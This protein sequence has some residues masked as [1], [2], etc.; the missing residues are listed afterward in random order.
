MKIL[1]PVSHPNEV[2]ALIKAGASQLYCGVLPKE[3][4]NTYTNIAPPNRREYAGANL[5]S[6]TQLKEVIIRSSKHKIG[7]MFTLNTDYAKSQYPQI[8]EYAKKAVSLGISGLLVADLSLVYLLK[9]KN[10]N[11]PIYMSVVNP[12]FNSKTIGL[13]RSMGI[14][15][16]TLDRHF[17]LKEIKMIVLSNP[18]MQFELF[19]LNAGSKNVDGFCG[20]CHGIS[21]LKTKKPEVIFD[22]AACY[23]NYNVKPQGAAKRGSLSI[24]ERIKKA[25]PYQYSGRKVCAACYLPYFLEWGINTAKIAGRDFPTEMKIK[26]IQFIKNLLEYI[27]NRKVKKEEYFCFTR[28]LFKKIYGFECGGFCYY[29]Q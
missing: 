12:S 8:I 24:A 23:L 15:M 14:K 27:K 6:W 1:A 5:S 20:F 9:K 17:S 22:S 18:G 4:R 2:D 13:F 11:I 29:S 26:D 25:F 16:I 21:E 28:A 10:I 19:V 3:W 7:V